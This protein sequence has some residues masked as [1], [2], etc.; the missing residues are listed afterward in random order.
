MGKAVLGQ[1]NEAEGSFRRRFCL[2]GSTLG[3]IATIRILKAI[4]VVWVSGTEMMHEG[5]I[6]TNWASLSIRAFKLY[7]I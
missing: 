5:C 4:H 7:T 1:S 2:C 3:S 6:E